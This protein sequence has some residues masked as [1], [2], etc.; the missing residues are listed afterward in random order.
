[1]NRDLEKL[2]CLDAGILRR[3]DERRNRTNPIILDKLK[4]KV[5][6][7]HEKMCSFHF[8][9]TAHSISANTRFSVFI[10]SIFVPTVDVAS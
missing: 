3:P 10:L 8:K 6:Q 1:M 9:I 4:L 7:T 2:K 5:C